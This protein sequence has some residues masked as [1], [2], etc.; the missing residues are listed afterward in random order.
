MW[1]AAGAGAAALDDRDAFGDSRV[2]RLVLGRRQKPGCKA[3]GDQA[4][5]TGADE[6]LDRRAVGAE[7]V[8]EY[9]LGYAPQSTGFLLD[10]LKKVGVSFDDAVKA[11]VRS[12]GGPE[13]A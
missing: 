8:E 7:A 11:G 5:G 2:E 9:E 12:A 1:H 3:G 13:R 4:L 6:R 10:G